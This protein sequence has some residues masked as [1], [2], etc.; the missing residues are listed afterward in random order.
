MKMELKV[1]GTV[2][3]WSHMLATCIA[4]IDADNAVSRQQ[5]MRK[6][7]NRFSKFTSPY[8]QI[9][10]IFAKSDHKDEISRILVASVFD[11]CIYCWGEQ[12]LSNFSY[13]FLH[14]RNNPQQEILKPIRNMNVDLSAGCASYCMTSSLFYGDAIKLPWTAVDLKLAIESDHKEFVSFAFS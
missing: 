8:Y 12:S 9:I 1:A 13:T 14:Q 11:S 2:A 6:Q 4:N 7:I 3:S 10:S 5:S